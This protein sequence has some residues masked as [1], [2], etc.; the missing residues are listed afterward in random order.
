MTLAIRS[1]RP[2]C[3]GCLLRRLGMTTHGEVGPFSGQI[4]SIHYER[5]QVVPPH[6]ASSSFV[7]IRNG[8][9]KVEVS[10]EAGEPGVAGFLFPGE[11]VV[12]NTLFR[13]AIVSALEPTTFCILDLKTVAHLPDRSGSMFCAVIE[14]LS[15]Q[16]AYDQQR[17]IEARIGKVR[18]RMLRF[19]EQIEQRSGKR[20]ITLSMSRDDIAHYLDTTP[21]S[22][23][24][25]I[26]QLT[27]EG[28]IERNGP[29][30]FRMIEQKRSLA[31]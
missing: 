31:S 17:L 1:D 25:A 4:S 5:G 19:L 2:L 14:E 22:V 13:S 15:A 18:D 24:R 30:H 16:A 23:S 6:C 21:E 3:T 29:R 26:S 9:L 10:N 12:T 20:S 27:R 7:M 11:P 8:L 28:V